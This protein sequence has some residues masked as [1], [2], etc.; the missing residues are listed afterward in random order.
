MHRDVFGCIGMYSGGIIYRIH[1]NIQEALPNIR[2]IFGN[3][4]THEPPES[5]T[6]VLARITF[7]FGIWV[8]FSIL[9]LM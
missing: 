2:D 4:G 5:V 7:V 9:K 3:I 6:G 8:I 1:P